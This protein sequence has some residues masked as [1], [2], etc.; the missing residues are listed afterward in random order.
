[1]RR[2][3]EVVVRGKGRVGVSMLM[4]MLGAGARRTRM[5]APEG[6]GM[7]RKVRVVEGRR[8]ARGQVLVGSEGERRR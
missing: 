7:T 3:G 6:A 2:A 5:R 8:R 4:T 1:M